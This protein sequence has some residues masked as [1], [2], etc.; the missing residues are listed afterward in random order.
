MIEPDVYRI[1]EASVPNQFYPLFETGKEW[2]DVRAIEL[3]VL[4]VPHKGKDKEVHL[5]TRRLVN[6]LKHKLGKETTNLI[7]KEIK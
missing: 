1:I 5:S 2:K 7:L 4:I 6:S 3:T